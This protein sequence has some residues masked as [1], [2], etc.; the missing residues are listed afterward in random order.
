MCFGRT[1]NTR[2]RRE[3][4]IQD[5]FTNIPGLTAQQ[6]WQLRHPDRVYGYRDRET[7]NR[8]QRE[9]RKK[10][11]DKVRA[12]QR[13]YKERDPERYRRIDLEKA[14]RHYRFLRRQVLDLLGGEC[15][16]CGFNDERALQVDHID[17]G[18]NKERIALN[19]ANASVYRRVLATNGVGYQ[20]LCANC[21]WI[22]RAERQE[23]GFRRG[24]RGCQSVQN[25]KAN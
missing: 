7:Y 16:R 17:G 18:G 22:K 13:A 5:E 19:G 15:V 8:W 10:N 23:H 11:P 14:K 21:N 2:L 6:R 25:G 1:R 20:L 12:I 9:W 24:V 4:K 3:M